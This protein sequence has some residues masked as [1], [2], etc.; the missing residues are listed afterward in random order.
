MGVGSNAFADV[1]VVEA[2]EQLRLPLEPGEAVGV[3]GEGVG[4]DLQGDLAVEL[5]IGRLPDLAH[6]AFA[7]FGGDTVMPQ[8]CAD[9]KRH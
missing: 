9:A 8:P 1:R 3:L 5:G 6:P 7:E 2:G 4:E